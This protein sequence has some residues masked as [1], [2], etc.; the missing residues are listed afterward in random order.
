MI[1]ERRKISLWVLPFSF[2][3]KEYILGVHNL[4]FDLVHFGRFDHDELYSMPIPL[5]NYYYSRLIKTK[6]DERKQMEKSQGVS[7]GKPPSSRVDG[8]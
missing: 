2:L 6:D 1:I 7:S 5:R 4:I 8:K 3:T